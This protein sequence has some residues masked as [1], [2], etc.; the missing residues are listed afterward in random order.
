M[1]IVMEAM[2]LMIDV[3]EADNM[4]TDDDAEEEGMEGIVEPRVYDFSD[5]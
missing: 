4:R 1:Q 3:D 2:S 5:P